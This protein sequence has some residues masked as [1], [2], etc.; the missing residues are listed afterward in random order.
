MTE[1]RIVFQETL[2]GRMKE[3][4]G[5]TYPRECCGLLFGMVTEDGAYVIRDTVRMENRISDACEKRTDIAPEDAA[6]IR[7]ED[8]VADIRN[9][10]YGMD[11]LELYGHEKKQREAG[12][13]VLG[14]YHS[15]PDHPSI[16]SDEDIRE[17]VPG[18][19]YIILSV[20]EGKPTRLRGWKQDAVAGPVRELRI[21][22]S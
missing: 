20:P 17:M 13:T 10:R 16:P 5:E 12:N 4:A 7:P 19:L 3:H 22:L 6:G 14:F 11:P 18:M 15:H 8:A 2:R 9:T 21:Y 1:E